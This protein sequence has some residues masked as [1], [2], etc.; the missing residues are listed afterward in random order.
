M[1]GV[2]V[3]L[4]SPLSSHQLVVVSVE[5]HSEVTAADVHQR[6]SW[7]G[8]DAL[9]RAPQAPWRNTR[10]ANLSDCSLGDAG[11]Q[12]FLSIVLPSAASPS[13]KGSRHAVSAPHRAH[14]PLL[15]PLILD[16]VGL[17]DCGAVWVTSYLDEVARCRVDARPLGARDVSASPCKR[18]L[19]R[20]LSLQRNTLGAVGVLKLLHASLVNPRSE[21]SANGHIVESVDPP[22]GTLWH[23][24]R[25]ALLA[26]R[27]TARPPAGRFSLPLVRAWCDRRVK[28]NPRPR[29]KKHHHRVEVLF[30]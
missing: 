2:L 24:C 14:L 28:L 25:V 30:S 5:G 16:G 7:L 12:A 20:T 8:T 22:P 13:N 27:G 1:A 17:T 26:G 18:C 11:V 29:Q 19:L 21:G 6:A 23:L 3:Q 9:A 4:V 15:E 10:V